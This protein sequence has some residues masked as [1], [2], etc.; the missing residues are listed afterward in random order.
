VNAQH[1]IWRHSLPGGSGWCGISRASRLAT[2]TVSCCR[3]SPGRL[4]NSRVNALLNAAVDSYP[5]RSATLERAS[6]RLRS[7]VAPTC[8]RHRFKY[9]IGDRPT[10]AVNFAA[11][12]ERDRP[13]AELNAGTVHRLSGAW[14]MSPS[15]APIDG[16]LSAPNQPAAPGG[17]S[18]SHVRTA[19]TNSTSIRL[20]MIVAAPMSGCCVSVDRNRTV[21]SSHSFPWRSS[22]RTRIHSGST[23]KNDL[24]WRPSNSNAPQITPVGSPPPP[25]RRTARRPP[26]DSPIRSVSAVTARAKAWARK[27]GSASHVGTFA[28]A[29]GF[30]GVVFNRTQGTASLEALRA[31]GAADLDGKILVDRFSNVTACVSSRSVASS[32]RRR[33]SIGVAAVSCGPT[34]RSSA[35]PWPRR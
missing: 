2:P 27:V 10:S 16:S 12:G 6:A 34:N 9:A 19:S 25:C 28:D 17:C 29:A 21:A 20:V 24:A 30:G 13:T 31:A 14:W 35:S 26:G 1:R 33:L 18:L 32:S 3:Y 7:N 23:V 5:T 22:F 4:P 11:N 8:N 15:A